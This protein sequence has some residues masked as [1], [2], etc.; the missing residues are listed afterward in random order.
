MYSQEGST[1]LLI[2]QSSGHHSPRV[3]KSKGQYNPRGV[4]KGGSTVQELFLSRGQYS[5]IGVQS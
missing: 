5:S 3:L 2:V 4:H 1:L